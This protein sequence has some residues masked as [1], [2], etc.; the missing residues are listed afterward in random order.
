MRPDPD[1]AG[2]TLIELM[3]AMALM[4][5]F[6]TIFL[7]GIAQ[8]YRAANRAEAMTTTQSQIS[9]AFGRLDTQIRYATCASPICR[10][11]AASCDYEHSTPYEAGGRTCLCNADPKCRRDHRLKQHP[12]WKAERH[13]D[14]TVTWTTPAGRTYTTEPTRYPI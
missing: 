13:P 14:G 6:G 11:P 3:V 1:D 9:I 5:V 12:R 7:S 2:V 8:M 10:R 4:S